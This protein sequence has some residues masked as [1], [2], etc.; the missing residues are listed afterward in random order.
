[1]VVV[2]ASGYESPNYPTNTIDNN[3]STRWSNEGIGSWIEYDLGSI[4]AISDVK[5]AWYN[6]NKRVNTFTISV[7]NDGSNWSTAFSGKS[8]GTT[9]NFE[10]YTISKSGRFVR[11]VFG[12]NT[13]NDWASITEVSI[14]S[15]IPPPPSPPPVPSPIPPPPP[16]TSNTDINGVTM[17]YP[18]SSGPS[19]FYRI[20]DNIT[21]GKYITTDQN[22][23]AKMTENNITFMR[24]TANTVTYS[25]GMPSGKTCRV[26]LN[27]GGFISTQAHTWKDPNV[28]YIWTPNDS[29][30]AEFTYYY[31]VVNNVHPHTTSAT[32]MRGG[33]HT[34]NNDPRASTFDIEYKIG[35]GD[36]SMEWALEYNHPDYHYYNTTKKSSNLSKENT[37][38]GRKTVCWTGKDGKVYVEDYVDWNPFN[39]SGSPAN[40][41]ILLQTQTVTGDSTYNKIPTWGGEFIFRQDGYQYVDVAIISIREIVPPS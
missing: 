38:I 40:N 41:W 5:I 7:S 31:R 1:M 37:W 17:L 15:S 26:N 9:T 20:G 13:S 3:L 10:H 21:S 8:S 14:Q 24:L 35:L 36:S 6:G 11:I 18:S 23:A 2:T 39:S 12:G 22:S 25:S 27:A 34:G 4:Q 33:I 29:K 28:Q 32:K 16:P 30:N 19:Y